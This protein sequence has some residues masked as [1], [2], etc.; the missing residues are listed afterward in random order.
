MEAGPSTF[1]AQFLSGLI[2]PA[3]TIIA[4]LV[5]VGIA[6][7]GGLQVA[8]GAMQLPL[9][10]RTACS[11]PRPRPHSGDG[12]R[13]DREAKHAGSNVGCGRGL[14]PL[15]EAQVAALAAEV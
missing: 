15:Y 2:M 1:S 8:S 7:V 12:G 14:R 4:N 10:A 6:V 5:Y 3:M 13:P 9:S 11:L